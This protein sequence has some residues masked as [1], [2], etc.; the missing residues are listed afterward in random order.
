[1][2]ELLKQ[3][4]IFKG[5]EAAEIERL[6]SGISFQARK[7]DAD[8]SI[9]FRGEKIDQLF[10]ILSGSL[11]GEMI[12]SQGKVLKIEDNF[13]GKA[14]AV[15]FMFSKKNEFP[16]TVTANEK[17]EVLVIHKSQLLFLMQRNER[18]LTNMLELI[19]NQAQFLTERIWALTFKTIKSKIANFII[20]KS[21]NHELAVI[22]LNQTQQ[23]LADYFGITRP[24]LARTLSEM[25]AEGSIQY[26]RGV[27]RIL[28][29][30]KL[31]TE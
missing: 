5:L 23:Q 16:V 31:K 24:S 26:E 1:M 9:A 17:S 30:E 29:F 12:D 7:V 18:I 2:Y 22:E 27:I 14:L 19:S 21:K 3:T 13:Q 11:R 4:P 20:Q 28:N 8:V 6:L 10:I 15:A 25:E